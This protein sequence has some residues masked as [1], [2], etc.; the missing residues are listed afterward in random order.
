MNKQTVFCLI[1]A[2]FWTFVSAAATFTVIR[3]GVVN[4]WSVLILALAV[5]CTCLQWMR[6]KNSYGKRSDKK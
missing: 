6:F 2:I 4:V 5:A 3:I 1:M